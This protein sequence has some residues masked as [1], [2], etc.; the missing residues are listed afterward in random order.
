MKRFFLLVLVLILLSAQAVPPARADVILPGSLDEGFDG[1]EINGVID[2]MILQ[3]DGKLIVAGSF[4]TVQGTARSGLARLN[5][6]GS[7]DTSFDPGNFTYLYGPVYALA[8]QP[9]GKLLIAG[10]FTSVQG[11]AINRIARLD[12]NGTLDTSFNP[13]DGADAP[14]RAIALQ[15][16]GSILLGGDFTTMNS[17]AHAHLARL[18]S[19]G[20]LDAAFTPVISGTTALV[21]DLAIQSDGKI[22]VVGDFE[23]VNGTPHVDIARLSSAGVL[24]SSFD[25]GSSSNWFIN[26]VALQEDGKFLVGGPFSA[27]DGA[28]STSRLVR[29]NSDGSVDPTYIPYTDLGRV[30]DIALRP[31]GKAVVAGWFNSCVVRLNNDGSQDTSFITGA[32][33]PNEFGMDC[34]S[35]IAHPLGMVLVGGGF[36]HIDGIPRE[37]LARLNPDGSTDIGF[38]IEVQQLITAVALQ[39]DS[40]I[41]MGGYFSFYPTPPSFRIARFHANSVVD[42]GFSAEVEISGSNALWSVFAIDV[43][44][45]HK[46]LIGGDFDLV[47]NISRR[48]I[49]RLNSDGSLDPTFDPGTGLSVPTGR[50]YVL[51]IILQENGKVIIAGDFTHFNGTARNN[52]ARLNA[53][54]S[55]DP[56]FDP[57]SGTNLAVHAVA[58]QPDGK[59]LIGGDFTTYNG[60]PVPRLARLNTDGSLDTSFDP[61]EGPN[62]SVAAIVIQPDGKILIGGD[63]T[64]VDGILRRRVARLESHGT[65]DALYDSSSGPNA[66]VSTL[67][68]QADGKLLLGGLFTEIEGDTR[69]HIARLDIDGLLDQNFAAGSVDYG[70]ISAIAVQP[71]GRI[72]IAGRVAENDYQGYASR[73][74]GGEWPVITSALPP[75]ITT[76]GQPFQH[77]FT[78]S[79]FPLPSFY[80][81]AGSLPPGLALDGESGLLSGTP[82]QPGPYTFE[83]TAY[84]YVVPS[85]SQWATIQVKEEE[86]SKLYTY[87]PLATR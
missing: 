16:D 50:F 58:L 37:H 61:G 72:V 26:T 76:A 74:N 53:D 19:N 65:V 69:N 59:I 49:A 20:A 2:D 6:D 68:L 30:M 73:L 47:D 36:D 25:P 12:K 28:P 24:D 22:I 32:F 7:L 14:I 70:V 44:T 1:G 81:S 64:L 11:T 9:D 87:L 41:L 62:G 15:D 13:G 38:D 71:D 86:I 45:D 46:I 29:L 60:S 31:D 10:N 56:T 33:T 66:L 4:S 5:P 75:T 77:T 21:S 39:P 43:Q 67:A 82:T 42:Q 40:K 8:L 18:E 83:I 84:N 34:G 27:F 85:D 23:Q 63:F 3:P 35:V 48:G 80:L 55:L 52:I 57:G 51:V 17:A 54:G 79:G 78:A